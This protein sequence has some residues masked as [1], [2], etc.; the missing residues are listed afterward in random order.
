MIQSNSNDENVNT[1]K[2]DSQSIQRQVN[3]LAAA[4][5][6]ILA[7]ASGEVS[8]HANEVFSEEH[9]KDLTL[10]GMVGMIDNE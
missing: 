2:I 6:R 3:E 1:I 7:L 8:L 4:G 5:Y 9:L 10:L